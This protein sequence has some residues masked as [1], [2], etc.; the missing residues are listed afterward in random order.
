MVLMSRYMGD[1]SGNNRP[2]RGSYNRFTGEDLCLAEIQEGSPEQECPICLETL[3][4]NE[5]VR[6]LPCRH[7]MHHDCIS[8]WFEQGQYNCPLCKMELSEHMTEQRRAAAGMPGETQ[9]RSWWFGP[10]GRRINSLNAAQLISTVD[11][12]DLGDLEMTEES[13]GVLT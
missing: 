13:P 7:A 1:D 10:R 4:P 3:Q 12:D 8:Q 5:V 2:S 11:E 6:I 9:Q